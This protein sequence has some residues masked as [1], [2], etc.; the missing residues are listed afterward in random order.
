M[1]LKDALRDTCIKD[2]ADAWYQLASLYQSQ[3]P[4]IAAE[5]LGTVQRYIGWMDIRLVAND[6]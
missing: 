3:Q 2:I 4:E 1:S 5:V 6:R